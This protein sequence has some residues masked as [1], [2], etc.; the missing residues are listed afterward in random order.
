MNEAISM[1]FVIQT[2][3]QHRVISNYRKSSGV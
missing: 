1:Q 3:Q 2:A